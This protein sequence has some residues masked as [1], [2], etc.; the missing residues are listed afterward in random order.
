[1]SVSSTRKAVT[2][3]LQGGGSHGAFTWG[4]LDRLLDEPRLD[5][6]AISGTSAGAINAALLAS[7]W[8]S[9]GI[10]GAK[11]ALHDFWRNVSLAG[12]YAF[13]PFQQWGD[14]LTAAYEGF[15]TN[16]VSPYDNPVYVNALGPLLGA[17]IDFDRLRAEPLLRFCRDLVIVEVNALKRNALPTTAHDIM[18][19]INEI[20]F[21][22]SLV[23]EIETINTLTKL[24]ESGQLINSKY[25]PIRFHSIAADRHRAAFDRSK[26][27]TDW[28][29]LQE[30][31]RLGRAEAQPWIADEQRFGK[32]GSAASVNIDERLVRP[33]LG[34]HGKGRVQP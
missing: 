16:I 32:V 21:N 13:N 19:R 34:R 10:D 12:K 26:S 27:D 11:K 31:F 30:L 5:I 17:A 14:S 4:V 9:A 23:Q 33:C 29:Y 28:D 24:I 22:A 7:G 20:T 8:A 15:F 25:Q 6:L 1:M 18:D 2:F 3:A